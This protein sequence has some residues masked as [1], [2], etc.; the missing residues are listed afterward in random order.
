MPMLDPDRYLTDPGDEAP[1]TCDRHGL[2]LDRYGDCYDC[3]QERD[4][5]ARRM[6]E[7]MGFVERED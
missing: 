3:E 7:A 6:N 2:E 4:D 5:E 1:E